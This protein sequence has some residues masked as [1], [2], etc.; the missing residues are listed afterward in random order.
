MAKIFLGKAFGDTNRK[1]SRR[2]LQ[3]YGADSAIPTNDIIAPST[4]VSAPIVETMGQIEK[5]N[6]PSV[7]LGK[8]SNAALGFDNSADLQ[9][10][11]NSLKSFNQ[12]LQAVSTTIA[13]RKRQVEQERQDYA[14][15]VVMEFFGDKKSSS[16][17]LQ[18]RREDLQSVVDNP[19]TSRIEKEAAITQLDY[20]DSNN[21]V[22][23][24]HMQSKNRILNIR[25]NASALS[26]KLANVT[27][28]IEGESVPLSSLSP[29]SQLYRNEVNKALYNDADGNRIILSGKES[30]QVAAEV[31]AAMANDKSR[32]AKSY[33]QAKKDALNQ[34]T[35][36]QTNAIATSY[37]SGEH[38][39]VTVESLQ[40]LVDDS[41]YM[42]LF[43]TREERNKF[44][45]SVFEQYISALLNNS[46]ETGLF[47]ESDIA[48]EPWEKLMTGPITDRVKKDGAINENLRWH[49]S[50]KENWITDAQTKY[51]NK[52]I[53]FK[54]LNDTVG[55][56]KSTNKLRDF[57]KENIEE[58]D[59]EISKLVDE[60]NNEFENPRLQSMLSKRNTLYNEELEKILR[61]AKPLHREK[62]LEFSKDFI[63]SNDETYFLSDK[64]LMQADLR[65]NYLNV[66]RDKTSV[67]KFRKQVN[68]LAN[69]GFITSDQAVN[70]LRQ[71][72]SIV[73]KV[74]DEY[75]D[76]IKKQTENILDGYAGSSGKYT[77]S[78]GQGGTTITLDESARVEAARLK[79][80]LESFEIFRNGIENKEPPIVIRTKIENYIKDGFENN[81]FGLDDPFVGVTYE[82]VND[83]NNSFQFKGSFTP[84][85]LNSLNESYK[86]VTPLL[87]GLTY[88]D[89]LDRYKKDK[90]DVDPTIQ[91]IIRQLG[92][93]NNDVMPKKFFLN[94][95]RKNKIQIKEEDI[96]ESI[97][98][99]YAYLD[100]T[101]SAIP[102]VQRL[103][104]IPTEMLFGAKLNAGEIRNNNPYNYQP[105]EG[106]QTIGDMLKISLTSDFTPDEAVIMAA[107]GMAES[108][109]RTH[110]HNTKGDDNS[111]GL[112]QINMLDRPGF[113]MGKERRGQFGLDSNEQLFDPLVNGKAAKYIYDMQGFEAWTVYRTGAYLDYLPAAREAL[114]SISD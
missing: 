97:N 15:S 112:W 66:F 92:S 63:K 30:K 65:K 68:N 24:P 5:M 101:P 83:L 51:N 33:I 110:A 32:Q 108:S 109:G 4:K 59:I 61:N 52:L 105:S 102:F 21:D 73:N 113:M 67:F 41:K 55:I 27:V 28:E 106:T 70:F 23:I 46:L 111:Y 25:T 71:T 17:K 88:V 76:L 91:K 56:T 40:T 107:I 90:T 87:D 48:I 57:Y 84:S 37:G 95:L 18:A 53:E 6:V 10:L 114:K 77:Q 94:E 36:S 34:S 44:I 100:K 75:D 82:S 80:K 50:Q 99:D 62:I 29:E 31:V 86:S 89:L 85:Q 45:D 72:D 60:T 20:I 3:K 39:A 78:G 79:I 14:G 7:Q 1:T 9:N 98:Q 16:E 38:L 49:K 26:S 42:S 69:A 19:E 8:F 104:S 64:K 93:V 103:A 54:K 81:K 58:M 35:L 12:N 74:F 47:L 96:P 13:K 43:R 2:M 22:L 11:A